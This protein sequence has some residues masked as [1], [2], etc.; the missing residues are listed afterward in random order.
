MDCSN[1]SRSIPGFNPT[2]TSAPARACTAYHISVFP[3]PPAA[4]SCRAAYSSSGCTCTESLSSEK[5]NFT[6]SGNAEPRSAFVPAHS[7]GISGHTLP[8]LLPSNGPEA[9]RHS[10]PVIQASPN[11]SVRFDFSGK[12]G[13]S[14]SEPHGRGLKIGSSRAGQRITRLDRRSAPAAAVLLRFAPSK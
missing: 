14:E 10:L 3:R 13:A 7:A 8:S 5:I 2:S 6:S 4:F 12:N 1:F 9:K 11:G